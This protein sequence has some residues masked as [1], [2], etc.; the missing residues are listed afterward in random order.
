MIQKHFQCNLHR[1]CHFNGHYM[2]FFFYSFSHRILFILFCCCLLFNPSRILRPVECNFSQWQK[3]KWWN[4]CCCLCCTAQI[5]RMCCKFRFQF[6]IF[7]FVCSIR[8]FFIYLFRL[9]RRVLIV[10][11]AHAF[12]FTRRTMNSN[13]WSIRFYA[14]CHTVCSISFYLGKI[15][16]KIKTNKQTNKNFNTTFRCFVTGLNRAQLSLHVLY[17]RCNLFTI[18]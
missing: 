13:E 4:F 15:K 10:V 9:N 17:E 14:L 1:H 2:L 11:N 5:I 6:V 16:I 7:V 3:I 8:F 18:W 12:C